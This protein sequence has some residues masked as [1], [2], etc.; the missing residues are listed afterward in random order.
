MKHLLIAGSAVLG[1]VTVA[2]ADP[3][4]P[5]DTAI[6]LAQETII[7]DGHVDIPYRLFKQWEDISVRTEG[8][9]FDYVRAMEGGLNAP[10]M[11]IYTPS[12]LQ[13]TPGAATEHAETSI[14]I[15]ERIA[16]E[17][18]DKFE[19]ATSVA[20]VRRITSAGKIALPMGM[21]NGAPIETDLSKLDHF[22]DRGIR[23][24][25]LTH[26]TANAISDSSYDINR[27]HDGLSDFG[28]EVVERMNALGIMVDVSHISDAAFWDVM[29]LTDVPVIASHSSAR[30]FTE[31]FERNMSD[32]MIAR[33]GEEDG[34]IMINFGSSFLTNEWGEW[35]NRLRAGYNGFLKDRGWDGT[36]EL[37]AAFEAGFT[38]QNP[39]P[40][41]S[42]EDVLDHID[43]VVEVAGI[44]HVGIGSDYDGVG[45]SLPTGL[46]DASTMPNLVQGLMDRGYSDDDIRKILSGNAFRVWSAVEAAAT[47]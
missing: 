7:L 15:V 10:F 19:V 42:I 43:H 23:Y 32:E 9:D 36:D 16:A 25:S 14:A 44:D 33:L 18:P 22:Y 21:E 38:A 1:L 29:E 13:Q 5:S 35:R 20:D 6:R 40:Y 30:A 2:H 8:G 17:N 45:D 27:P 24:V 3:L 11:S 47:E 34:V 4:N 39:K 46:K 28:V 26:A 12:E 41:A 31:G 37:Y